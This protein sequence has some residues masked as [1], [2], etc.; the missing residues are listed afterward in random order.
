VNDPYKRVRE[1]TLPSLPFRVLVVD[2]DELEAAQRKLLEA[3]ERKRRADRN[4]VPEK[5]ER[6]KEAES[7]KRALARA[8]KAFEACWETIQIT[9]VE[10]AVFEKLKAEH[11]P[12]AEQLKDDPDAGFDKDTFQPALL[13]ACAEGGK[14]VDEWRD[15]LEH[16]FSTGERQELFTTA[17]AVNAG[18]RVVESVVLPKD[19]NAILGLLSKWR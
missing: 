7:A 3:S 6:V 10:P 15:M 1:R 5:P 2:G 4:L 18:T 17:L 12:T 13:A 19:S 8:E 11:P 9:A 16:Q 14:T